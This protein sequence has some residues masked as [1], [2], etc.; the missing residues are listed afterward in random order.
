MQIHVRHPD[1]ESRVFLEQCLTGID[2]LALMVTDG[3][4][5]TEL[6]PAEY[7]RRSCYQQQ[8]RQRRR[9]VHDVLHRD[10]RRNRQRYSPEIKAEVRHGGYLGTDTLHIVLHQPAQHQRQQQDNADLL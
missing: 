4:T 3:T 2:L 1:A 5:N 9:A 6:Y 7:K 10:T 8:Q